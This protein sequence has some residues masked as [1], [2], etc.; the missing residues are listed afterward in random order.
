MYRWTIR[1]ENHL[2]QKKNFLQFKQLL[3]NYNMDRIPHS[4]NVR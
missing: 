1:K 3:G 2:S 4:K